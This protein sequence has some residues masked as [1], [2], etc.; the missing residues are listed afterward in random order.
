MPQPP[1]LSPGAAAAGAPTPDVLLPYEAWLHV[2]GCLPAEDAD[3]MLEPSKAL[4]GLSAPSARSTP[5][6]TAQL[7]RPPTLRKKHAPGVDAVVSWN[8]RTHGSTDK[9]WNM[10]GHAHRNV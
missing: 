8:R 3:A 2:E 10:V 7:G 4:A 6:K 5:R 1:P 9:N